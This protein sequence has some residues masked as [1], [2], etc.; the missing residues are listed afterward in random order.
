LCVPELEE[1]AQKKSTNCGT[2]VDAGPAHARPFR[3]IIPS[4]HSCIGKYI[5]TQPRN[6]RLFAILSLDTVDQEDWCAP[7]LAGYDHQP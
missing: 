4:A 3:D 5:G 7:V 6:A 2:S 1:I